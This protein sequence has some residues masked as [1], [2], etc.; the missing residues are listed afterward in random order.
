MS[1]I[2]TNM[3]SGGKKWWEKQVGCRGPFRGTGRELPSAP[4]ALGDE[5]I[6]DR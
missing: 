3:D 4:V 2:L 6:I 1:D 5:S